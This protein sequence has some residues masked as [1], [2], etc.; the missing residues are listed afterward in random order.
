MSHYSKPKYSPP[1]F[2]TVMLSLTLT[3]CN[4]P[5][6]IPGQGDMLKLTLHGEASGSGSIQF[7]RTTRGI[8]STPIRPI[9]EEME[10]DYPDGS[11]SKSLCVWVCVV[12]EPPVTLS[13][14]EKTDS[15]T[16]LPN[17]PKSNSKHVKP[18][19]GVFKVLDPS[20]SLDGCTCFAVFPT[21]KIP[22]RI[23]MLSN[24]KVTHAGQISIF[25]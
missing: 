11:T 6:A 8:E 21:T 13:P 9:T 12:P 16:A 1:A 10:C 23:R 24:G 3:T 15:V 4:N 7:S 17:F 18:L 20:P 5:T 2:L 14:G 22:I 19:W 25:K